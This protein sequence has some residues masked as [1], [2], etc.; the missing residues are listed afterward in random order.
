MGLQLPFRRNERLPVLQQAK[1][2]AETQAQQLVAV[3]EQ[4]LPR[5]RR[6]FWSQPLGTALIAVAVA[7]TAV[8]AIAAFAMRRRGQDAPETVDQELG[9]TS[10][11]TELYDSHRAAGDSVP[12]STDLVQEASKESFPASDAPVWGH[13]P[14]VPVIRQG[15]HK[16]ELPYQ[17]S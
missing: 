12:M 13:G 4:R 14:D 7:G 11:R 8:A 9:L 5:R 1:Q 16:E 10:D 6:S 17:G 3:V 2:L 15:E